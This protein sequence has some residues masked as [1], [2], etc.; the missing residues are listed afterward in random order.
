MLTFSAEPLIDN[1]GRNFWSRC[2][3]SWWA[4][5]GLQVAASVQKIQAYY[6]DYTTA[7]SQV[8]DLV[9]ELDT[10]DGLSRGFTI[11]HNATNTP[12]TAPID[13]QCQQW[14]LS[15]RNEVADVLQG[16]DSSFMKPTH[17][18]RSKFV[19]NKERISQWLVKLERAKSM[20][21]LAKQLGERYSTPFIVYARCLLY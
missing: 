11:S 10:L 8:Q 19:L 12:S 5:L 2:R 15:V 16:L 6:N 9:Q 1:N 7:P 17:R 4:S 14:C 3:S 20:L 18:A 13:E 21:L